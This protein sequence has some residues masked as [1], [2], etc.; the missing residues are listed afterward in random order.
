MARGPDDAPEDCPFCRI[1]QGDDPAEIVAEGGEWLAFSPLDPATV[2]HTLVIPR[3]HATDFWQ[4]DRALA[5]ELAR[6][7]HAVGLAI[8]RA[9]DPP[10]MNL[11][12]SAGEIAEQ[13]VFHVHLHLVPRWDGDEFGR[14]W[15]SRGRVSP[16][17]RSESARLIRRAYETREGPVSPR[18]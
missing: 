13:T 10:G 16:S 8:D 7:A 6:A 18:K 4:V 11:I 17:Q 3:A 12:T 2:G 14:I 5:A 15:P 9:L 1:A